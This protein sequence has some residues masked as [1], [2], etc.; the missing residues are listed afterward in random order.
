MVCFRVQESSMNYLL[1][2]GLWYGGFLV[3]AKLN[4]NAS[5]VI[6]YIKKI[7]WQQIQIIILLRK[8][9][10]TWLEALT[11]MDS[12]TKNVQLVRLLRRIF[13]NRF[14][15]TT[16]EK[17]S[18]YNLDEIS[19]LTKSILLDFPRTKLLNYEG[20]EILEKEYFKEN[21]QLWW[22]KQPFLLEKPLY[23]RLGKNDKQKINVYF[24]WGKT[25]WQDIIINENDFREC[26][27]ILIPFQK[28][29][30]EI[31][32]DKTST[33]SSSIEIET[34]LSFLKNMN[35]EL[36]DWKVPKEKFKLLDEDIKTQ[37]MI[38][39][40]D[41]VKIM[42]KILKSK[43]P[44]TALDLALANDRKFSQFIDYILQIIGGIKV[45]VLS[46]GSRQIES[47]IND[48]LLPN[49]PSSFQHSA[50]TISS[51]ASNNSDTDCLNND[52]TEN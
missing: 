44:Y 15:S 34:D 37:E 51:S 3:D 20:K 19:I 18:A 30:K 6:D 22:M 26:T 12:D 45:I 23:Q 9:P 8:Q 36:A 47:C 17:L 13:Q 7:I 49:Y 10:K 40:D 32:I 35:Y 38:N 11:K 31:Q 39:D 4:E 50:Q 42:L 41:L 29:F 21:A 33:E 16:T 25:S 5:S 43:N 52:S 48:I 14:E 28:Y 24:S 27:E 2:Q 46:D 1:K